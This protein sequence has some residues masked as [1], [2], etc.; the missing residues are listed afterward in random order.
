MNL[1]AVKRRW[2]LLGAPSLAA[3]YRGLLE[4]GEQVYELYM[5]HPPEAQSADVAAKAV[6]SALEEYY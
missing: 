5:E 6:S 4:A 3:Y 1:N 2:Q